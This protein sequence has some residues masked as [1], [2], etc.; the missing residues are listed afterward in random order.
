MHDDKIAILSRIFSDFHIRKN[1]EFVTRC[2]TKECKADPHYFSKRKLEINLSTNIFSCW[3]CRY[4]GHA[5]SLVRKYGSQDLASRFVKIL[6]IQSVDDGHVE[7]ALELPSEYKFVL[8]HYRTSSI[9]K[10]AYEWLKNKNVTDD[11]ILQNRVGVCESGSYRNRLIFPSF[12]NSCKLDYFDTRHLFDGG[13]CKWLKCSKQSRSIVWNESFIDWN[14]Q[15]IVTESVKTYL[16]FFQNDMN[17]VPNNGSTLNKRYKLYSKIL[18]DS[19]ADII[20]AFDPEAYGTA[21]KIAKELAEYDCKVKIAKFPSQPD[22]LSLTQFTECL[23]ESKEYSQM[24]HLKYR[25]S[26]L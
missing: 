1:I 23:H 3:R 15:L 4:S 20:L 26:N 24:D 16:K 11:T 19:C 21:S 9:V 22:E 13:T 17:I 18:T 5:I 6:G 8:D 7:T 10:I 12:D 25:I 14:R 2:P